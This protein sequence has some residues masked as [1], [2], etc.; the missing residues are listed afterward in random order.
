MRTPLS[1]ATLLAFALPGGAA[2]SPASRT[3]AFT[4]QAAVTGLAPGQKT[5]VW[6]PVPSSGPHQKIELLEL[7]LPAKGR[8]TREPKYG[9]RLLFVEA[10]A[11]ARG[12]VPLTVTYRVT[13]REVKALPDKGGK[14]LADTGGTLDKFLGPNDHVPIT[15]KPLD[16][17]RGKDLPDDPLAAAHR[18]YDIVFDH[19]QYSK[20]G[21]GWGNGDASW[22]CQSGYGNCSDFH[23]LFISLA[24]SR[25]I[26]ARFEIGFPLLP[27]GK[28]SRGEIPG[29]HCWGWFRVV[30]QGWIPVDIS[31]ARKD[32]ELQDYY[33]GNLTADRVA[34]T[35]GRDLT[36]VPRQAGPPLNFFIYPYAEVAGKPVG[37]DRIRKKFTF[38]DLEE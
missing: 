34:F 16:L 12:E 15:G 5:R 32:P 33:F 4:Y 13:R 14:P 23:S 29:Y 7:D 31:E 9:N 27:A 11:N 35:T 38:R 19:L 10:R 18:I 36:L 1:V 17:L 20:K 21:E 8:F 2:D 22:A 30:G 6:L 26:P 37:K 3:F 24:R 28:A 25:K